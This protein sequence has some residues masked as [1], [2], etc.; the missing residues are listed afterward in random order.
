MG[1]KEEL[2]KSAFSEMIIDQMHSVNFNAENIADTLAIKMLGEI[3]EVLTDNPFEKDDFQ[4]VEEIVSIF[5][6]YH[7]DIGACHDFS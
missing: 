7:I 3:Q 5:E 1:I 2:I 4:R 6:K